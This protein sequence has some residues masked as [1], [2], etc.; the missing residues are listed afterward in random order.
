MT[1][2]KKIRIKSVKFEEK[3]N[4]LNHCWVV[5]LQSVDRASY[6]IDISVSTGGR[7][8]TNQA[9]HAPNVTRSYG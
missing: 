2:H 4:N 1:Q 8:R 9:I 3:I 5:K 7:T 6:A